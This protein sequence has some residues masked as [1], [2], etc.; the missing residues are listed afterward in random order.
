MKRIFLAV[1]LATGLSLAVTL[2]A[3]ADPVGNEQ[4]AC[5]NIIGGGAFYHEA[6]EPQN[7]VEGSISF[8]EPSCKDVSYTMYVTYISDGKEKTKSQTIRGDGTTD[9]L[10]FNISNVSSDTHSVC[11]YYETAKGN[12]VIDRAPDEGC[13]TVFADGID[14]PAGGDFF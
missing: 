3:A 5:G 11:V 7:S 10:F 12:N 14:P 6:T 9:F 13:V 1:L 8:A 2:S 4:P